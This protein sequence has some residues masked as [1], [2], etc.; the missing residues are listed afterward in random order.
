MKTYPGSTST[1]A[2]IL[3]VGTTVAVLLAGSGGRFAYASTS[4][5]AKATLVY[6]IFT[7]FTYPYFAPMAQ[8]VTAGERTLLVAEDA[9]GVCGPVQL[10]LDLP[11]NQ[12]SYSRPPRKSARFNLLD[13]LYP[14]RRGVE[15]NADVAVIRSEFRRKVLDCRSG[16]SGPLQGLDDPLLQW[17][18]RKGSFCFGG[19]GPGHGPRYPPLRPPGLHRR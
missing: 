5:R 13:F 1:L 8:G 9:R 17:S 16:L 18:A 2:T 7:G 12:P 11:E 15:P 4:L 6:F 3:A 14:F 10:I 19:C